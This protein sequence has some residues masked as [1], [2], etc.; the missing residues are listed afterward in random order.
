MSQGTANCI[1][2]MKPHGVYPRLSTISSPVSFTTCCYY[3]KM[4]RLRLSRSSVVFGIRTVLTEAF[5]AV[6]HS[7]HAMLEEVKLAHKR[8]L[9][10]PIPSSYHS[11]TYC[12]LHTASLW[13]NQQKSD[14]LII[15]VLWNVTPCGLV[16]VYW[17]FRNLL[18]RSSG[19]T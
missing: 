19:Q 13:I 3:R 7:L 6:P 11:A 10:F 17:C 5:R 1:L 8:F 4:S 15:I 9:L 16:D 18:P 2:G 14:K 12:L